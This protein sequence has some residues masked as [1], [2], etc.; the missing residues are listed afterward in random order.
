MNPILKYPGAKWRM[1][2]WIIERM[3]THIGYVEPF[4][5]SGA[6]FFNKTPSAIETI[7]DIDGSVVRFF[8]TCREQP[9]ALARAIA[10]TPWSREEFLQ[11]DFRGDDVDDVEAARQF[12]VRCWQTFGARTRC[13]T[14]WRHT[15]AKT[16]NHG[17]D[18][19][20]MWL[21]LPDVVFEVA[22]RLIDAQI[23]NRPALDVI[24]DNDGPEVLVYADP[25]YVKATR[26]LNGDQ[27]RHEMDDSEHEQLLQTLN[28]FS[29]MVLISGYDCE[30]YRDMLHGW[31]METVKTKAERGVSRT[32]CLW[33]NPAVVERRGQMMM[34]AVLL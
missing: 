22:E 16:K 31:S 34:E 2:E 26:T 19:P 23:D 28:A 21:R 18:N 10:L 30:L 6:V 15:A 13:K 17:P 7:N 33:C 4:F 14:G 24:R 9:E 12:A 25:P 5:G 20:R 1:A 29:G 27:Y 11:S 8:K 3:P 32:E